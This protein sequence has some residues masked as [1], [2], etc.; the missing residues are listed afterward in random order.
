MA[1][2]VAGVPGLDSTLPNVPLTL[3]GITYHLCFDFNA[4][5]LVESETGINLFASDITK[6]SPTN[7]RAMFFSSLLKAHPE[8]TLE[9]AGALI[10]PKTLPA[11]A[12]AV[13]KAWSDST[14]E[15]T[16]NTESPNA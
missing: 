9:Q 5:A 16:E 7:F 3:N 15:N 10:T 1:K 4:C 13:G 11:I 14:A 8:F 12:T 2:K 6:F